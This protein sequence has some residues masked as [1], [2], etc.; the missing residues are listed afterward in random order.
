[1][2]EERRRLLQATLALL[3]TVALT[4][5]AR[6][7]EPGAPATAGAHDFDFFLGEWRV[8]HRRL[9]RRLVNANDW[10]EFEGVTRCVSLLG[11]LAN[12]ND[13]LVH[14]PSGAYRG[15]GLRA[16]NPAT[17]T[18]GDWYLDGRDPT[19]IEMHG[20]GRF[21]N[22]VATFYADDVFEGA[23]IRVRGV[24]SQITKQ[25]FR[26]QQAF[27]ADGGRT[28]ETNYVMEQIRTA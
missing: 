23:P 6:A 18:W 14:R 3:P 16:F 1:M 19:R 22:G 5:T 12:L 4:Q 9:T 8:R 24:W 27:S 25:S 13:S 17:N 26:W 15:M 2:D 28:W 20:L 7:D 11:G 10:E 21:E